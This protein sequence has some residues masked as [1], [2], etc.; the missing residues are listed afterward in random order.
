[1]NVYCGN[2]CRAINGATAKARVNRGFP[3]TSVLGKATL[4]LMEKT[5]KRRFFQELFPKLTEFWEKLIYMF[6]QR[7]FIEGIAISGI[8][9]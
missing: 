9:G 8:K 3:K 2:G 1:M 4:D 7:Y 5:A 6:A